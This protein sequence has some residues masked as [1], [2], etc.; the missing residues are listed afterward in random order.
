VILPR[1][2]EKLEALPEDINGRL[3]LIIEEVTDEA[4]VE[5]VEVLMFNG[6]YGLEIVLHPTP[7][8]VDKRGMQ[9]TFNDFSRQL[10]SPVISQ[11]RDAAKEYLPDCVG[12]E[13]GDLDLDPLGTT[14]VTTTRLLRKENQQIT[15]SGKYT[16][17]PLAQ[18]FESYQTAAV[19]F[20]YQVILE[21]DRKKNQYQMAVRMAIYHP[22]YN[23]TGDKG[24]AKLLEHGHPL[25][26]SRPF[27]PYKFVSNHS[28]LGTEY[29]QTTYT[30]RIDGGVEYSASYDYRKASRY[31]TKYEVRK[32]ADKLKQL[33]LGQVEHADLRLGNASWDPV[34]KD[35]DH[36]ARFD[37]NPGQLK[38]F[39]ELVPIQ[40]RTNPWLAI[41]GRSQPEFNTRDIVRQ[42]GEDVH[43]YGEGTLYVPDSYSDLANE[44]KAAHKTLG[45]FIETWFSERGD[46]IREVKQTSESVPDYVLRATEDRIVAL[47]QPVDC[48]DVAVEA[49][50]KTPTKP[51]KTLVNVE[52]AIASDQHVI[53]VY[54]SAK[55]AKRGYGHV[56]QPYR[57]DTDHG[58][59]LFT[60][61]AD[62]TD[63]EGRVVVCEG[64]TSVEWYLDG[65]EV[66]ARVNGTAIASGDASADV[67]TFN[68]RGNDTD[69][70]AEGDVP[71]V[72]YL[73]EHEDD[74]GY[75]IETADGEILVERTSKDAQVRNWTRLK[76]PHIPVTVSYLSHVTIMYRDHEADELKR[77]TEDPDFDTETLD[78]DL[79]RQP[80][81]RDWYK[82]GANTYCNR[83][84]VADEGGKL[85]YSELL[86]RV[87]RWFGARSTLGEPHSSEVGRALPDEIRD[88]K[89]GGTNNKNPYIAGYRWLFESGID[90]PHRP[91]PETYAL[92]GRGD[93]KDST[94]S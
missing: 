11:L 49:E 24:L 60:R 8:T 75:R 10:H 52:R 36:Y 6:R 93:D 13:I 42:I 86:K 3:V 74:D 1:D 88:A 35:R 94:D 55:L 82:A 19:P 15:Q 59:Y 71:R 5:N 80:G 56:A 78:V 17:S 25:D 63:N 90:S 40:F 16:G 20:L 58:V 12:I 30:E 68:Y 32:T 9:T 41:D 29:W 54:P 38:P 83:Y 45:A 18:I 43:G 26:I 7:G 79:D 27:A 62:V 91:D 2:E 65:Q 46:D 48:D 31:K 89:K 84:L 66:T 21:K 72:R 92:I 53:L 28:A 33:I 4:G 76:A 64:D 51:S 67:G 22:D 23:Y 69:G 87:S 44:G 81:K 70:D 57:D 37:L 39:I 85:P 14:D 50:S 47:D 61:T 34:Y 73:V 77:Y